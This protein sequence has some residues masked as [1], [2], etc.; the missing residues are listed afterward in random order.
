VRVGWS[1]GSGSG[2]TFPFPHRAVRLPVTLPSEP[3]SEL[4][5]WR[6]SGLLGVG[7]LLQNGCTLSLSWARTS[8]R[9]V[10]LLLPAFISSVVLLRSFAVSLVVPGVEALVTGKSSARCLDFLLIARVPTIGLVTSVA[11]PLVSCA[12][13]YDLSLRP[14]RVRVSPRCR[15]PSCRA[16]SRADGT[17]GVRPG[18]EPGLRRRWRLE[19]RQ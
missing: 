5:G 1:G 18:M 9:V 17:L 2:S 4:C 6:R 13:A 3:R 8:F 15:R 16:A 19:P 14:F 7:A 12:T 11:L 10:P